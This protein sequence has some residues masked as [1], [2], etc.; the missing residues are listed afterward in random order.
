M[1]PMTITIPDDIPSAV[2]GEEAARLASLASGGDVLEL[3][4]QY[5]F[6]TV[7]LA[8]AARRVTSVDWHQGDASIEA[9]GGGS[10]DTWA[11]YRG[12][13]A[14]Y[15]VAG[16]VDARR[17]RFADVLPALARQGAL[18]DGVFIDAQHDSVSVQADLDLA[19]PL[20]RPGGW[21]AFHDYGRSEVT[22]HP[23]FGVTEVADRFGITGVADC[24]AWGFVS[25]PA[26]PDAARDR[27]LTVVGMP[28]APDGSGYYRM[29]LPFKHLAG[30]SRH[31]FAI[32]PPG[33]RIDPPTPA[34]LED[35]DVL[36]MQRPAH[37][38]GA[39]Q[40][41]RIA[42]HAA[43]VYET[44]DDI[45]TMEPSNDPFA[46]DP[47]G[48]ESVRYCL[49]RAEMVTVSTPYL[50]ELYAPF[51]SN[52][53]VLPNFVKAELLDMPR[54]RRDRVT[55]GYQGGISHLVD[56]CAVQDELAGVL[57][58]NPDVDM[59]WIGA[60]TSPLT[61]IRRP[62]LRDRCRFTRWSDDVGDYYRAVDFDIAIAPLAGG[63]LVPF[64]RAK[65]IDSSMRIS[66]NRGVLEAGSVEPGMKVWLNGWCEVQAAEHQD[67]REG[68]CITTVR[69]TQVTV[70]PE[71]RLMDAS[72]AWRQAQDL[73]IGESL[74]LVKEECPELPYQRAP[75][76]ADGR[77]TRAGDVEPMAFLD[78]AEGPAITI[79]ETWGRILGLFTGDG[80]MTGK[81]AIRFSCDGQDADL[82]KMLIAD[83]ESAGFKAT[84][85]QVTTY[86]GKVTRRRSVRVSSAH[87]SRFLAGLGAARPH[88]KT[89]QRWERT[90]RVPD[91]IFRS[92]ASVRAAFLAGL[93]EADGCTQSGSASV[94]LTT[95]SIDLARDVH[96]LLWSIGIPSGLR[97]T[98]P[99]QR[100]LYADRIYRMV[101]LRSAEARLFLAQ[102]GFLSERKRT[103][104]AEM[105]RRG[106]DRDRNRTRQ[107]PANA[108][109]PI[110]WTDE[111][112]SIAP[113]T[114][115]PVDIQVEGEAF[116]AAGVYSHNS[117]LKALE[118]A[119]RGIPVVAQDMEPYRDFVKDGETG[120]L[121][122]TPEQ[123]AKRLTELIHDGQARDELGR[124]A[125]EQ[126][127]AH[128]IQGNWHLF[129]AAYESAAG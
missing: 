85:E 121:V 127:K 125:R 69:G 24:L 27:V 113:C 65:C 46:M 78:A 76:P 95:K 29:Y 40:F 90:L 103:R 50:A 67:E 59:H 101:S 9:M 116:S 89:G 118:A 25:G 20:I 17:G 123:W 117:H 38:Y 109:R 104:L 62:W 37:P 34:D 52:I 57:E 70:T 12:N 47:R 6:S 26:G 31:V 63:D 11:A 122:R 54:K 108:R 75:W 99:G 72:G 13:L 2:T 49:R 126:A 64:N 74:Q 68:L 28:F 7:V 36:V 3:G 129:E 106:E 97:Q 30:N 111:I 39:R 84:T 80:C 55:I 83:L 43:R 88:S 93:F 115:S 16:K 14:R 51:N 8:Q 87:L 45:L 23:G 5:G 102:V 98:R 114:V 41:D 120:Y 15:G 82:I 33:R 86:D 42:G 110:R 18:F 58:A 21:V 22:G 1:A 100:S 81:T 61:W 71:H 56:M 96:R 92:P 66:T 91:V 77:M 105:V 44:D 79:T 10:E 107:R 128:T 48:P 124:N 32:P 119:A 112:A 53:R 60:D 73:Q 94:T 4:A 19:L 35:V